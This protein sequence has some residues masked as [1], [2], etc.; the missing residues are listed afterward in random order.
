MSGERG[1]KNLLNGKSRLSKEERDAETTRIAN[2]NKQLH[3]E[4]RKR[5]LPLFLFFASFQ[6]NARTIFSHP[7]EVGGKERESPTSVFTPDLPSK[8]SNPLPFLTF[9]GIKL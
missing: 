1:R 2:D 8:A 7:V 6:T 3:F 9:F 5:R 4:P